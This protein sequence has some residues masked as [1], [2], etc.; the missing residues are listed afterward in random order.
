MLATDEERTRSRTVGRAWWGGDVKIAGGC[1]QWGASIQDP[2]WWER[3]SKWGYDHCGAG[4]GARVIVVV[5]MLV[6]E[7]YRN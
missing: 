1:V 3:A 6:L 7:L 4:L 5:F 2:G